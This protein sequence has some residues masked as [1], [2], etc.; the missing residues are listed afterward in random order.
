MSYWKENVDQ[1]ISTN[2]FPLLEHAGSIS[3]QEVED[4]TSEL[5]LGFDQRRKQQEALEADQADEADL[6]ALEDK[7]KHREK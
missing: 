4:Q 6:Q 3:H 1:I 5:Y 2:G 7:L